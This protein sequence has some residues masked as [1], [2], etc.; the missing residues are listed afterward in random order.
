MGRPNRLPSSTTAPT[1][2]SS[3]IDRPASRS[4]NIEVLCSPTFSAPAM[5]CSMETGKS[6]PKPAGD[7][8]H[9]LHDVPDHRTNSRI[10]HH[11]HQRGAGQGADRI[12]RR[13]TQNLYP[14]LVPDARGDRTAQAGSDQRLGNSAAA[15]GARAI[16]FAQRNTVALDV[17]NHSRGRN[18][19][20]KVNDGADYSTALRWPR[21]SPRRDRHAPG[22]IPPIR[23][24]NHGSTTMGFHSAC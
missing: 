3:S 19:G 4:C 15:I 17:L 7:G 2:A 6:M 1:N 13:V 14:N 9:F 21:K 23:H 20:R 22:A 16:R 5:R 18:L 12:E 10:A 11:L 8:F 24:R